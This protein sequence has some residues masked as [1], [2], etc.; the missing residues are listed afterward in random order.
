MHT[1]GLQQ[2]WQN[3]RIFK[4]LGCKLAFYVLTKEVAEWHTAIKCA[5]KAKEK[6]RSNCMRKHRRGIAI[7]IDTQSQCSGRSTYSIITKI[8][9]TWHNHVSNTLLLGSLSEYA[10]PSF[11][12][13]NSHHLTCATSHNTKTSSLSNFCTELFTCHTFT[14]QYPHNCSI[15]DTL[16]LSCLVPSSRCCT[17]LDL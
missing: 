2:I 12:H 7:S 13:I 9:V 3:C 16:K 14:R 1:K 5:P 10:K 17:Y 6:S 15:Y 11:I 8:V 4:H